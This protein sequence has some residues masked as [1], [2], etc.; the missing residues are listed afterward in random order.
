MGAKDRFS[1]R[2]EKKKK[3]ALLV[4]GLLPSL[5]YYCTYISHNK[6][7]K[8]HLTKV[9]LYETYQELDNVLS[10]SENNASCHLSL[11]GYPTSKKLSFFNVFFLQKP[12]G[13]IVSFKGISGKHPI[14]DLGA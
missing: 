10:G 5:Q 8:R 11:L 4:P 13:L 14:Q 3:K 1:F 2:E 12:L 6:N 9:K 7:A